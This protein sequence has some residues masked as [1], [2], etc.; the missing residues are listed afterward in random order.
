MNHIKITIEDL[1]E[2]QA[3]DITDTYQFKLTKE[4][5][6]SEHKLSDMKP[7]DPSVWTKTEY[8][9]SLLKRCKARK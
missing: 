3:V 7:R 1:Q 5:I 4:M 6:K 2:K 8:E 9:R